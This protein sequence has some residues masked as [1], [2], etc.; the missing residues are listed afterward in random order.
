MQK[1]V[2]IFLVGGIGGGFAQQGF[3]A[4]TKITSSLAGTFSV[5]V[6]S[7]CAADPGFRPD[8]FAFHAAPAWLGGRAVRKLRWLFLAWRFLSEHRREPYD[9]LFSFWGYP[10]GVFV[11]AL[12]KLVRKPSMITILGAEAASVPSIGYG[13]LRRPIPRRLVLA[14]CARASV[15]IVVAAQQWETL[16]RYGLERD[17]VKVI[18]LGMDPSMFKF[19]PKGLDPPLKILH[20]ANL[21]EV[22]DQVTLL[23]GFAL[24]R[25]THDAR[26]RVVGPDYLNGKLQRL[27]AELGVAG[28]VEFVGGLPYDD[29]PAQYKWADMFVLTSLSESQ[30]NA[31]TEAAMS[32]V[33]QVSTPVG[34]INDLGDDVAVVVRTGDPADL[35]A[36]IRAIVADPAA[37]ADKVERARAWAEHHD[38][39]WTVA[40]LTEAI[41]GAVGAV[42]VA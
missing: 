26:L 39:P 9:V 42:G 30:N 35:A 22:K 21:T 25:R 5:T 4:I 11:V 29:I 32:G 12:A 14:T 17:D 31:L 24:L 27:A 34:H 7:L 23:R 19:A 10:M 2:A 38:L 33:L 6:Y 41:N 15:V 1:R 36:K 28:D 3:P 8:R 40:R 13:Q 16:R 18:P 20:V 37:W